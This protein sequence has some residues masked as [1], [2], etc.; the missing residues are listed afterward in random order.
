MTRKMAVIGRRDVGTAAQASVDRPRWARGVRTECSRRRE[1]ATQCD[2]IAEYCVR[3]VQSE[4]GFSIG[5][6][7]TTRTHGRVACTSTAPVSDGVSVVDG[8][9]RDDGS[10]T[11]VAVPSPCSYAAPAENDAPRRDNNNNNNKDAGAL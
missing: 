7:K 3:A 2:Q 6:E 4:R 10:F 9:W 11:D 5:G 1:Y 8:R